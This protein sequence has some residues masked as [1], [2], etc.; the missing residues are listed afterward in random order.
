MAGDW[1]VG[2]MEMREEGRNYLMRRIVVGIGRV[3]KTD[4]VNI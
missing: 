3:S 1:A 4:D 2:E